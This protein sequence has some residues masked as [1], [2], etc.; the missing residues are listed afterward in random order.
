M[1]QIS[2]DTYAHPP[3]GT[4]IN[5]FNLR[6]D[7]IDRLLLID[8]SKDPDARYRGFEI[9][10]FDDALTGKGMLVIA[11][12]HDG[13]VDVY[14]QPGLRMDRKNYNVVGKGLHKMIERPF[15]RSR[16]E[17]T[18]TGVS[19]QVAFNDSKGRPIKLSILEEGGVPTRP[20][21]MLA[22][23]GAGTENPPS[24]PLVLL[25]DFYFV[26]KKGTDLAIEIDGKKHQPDSIPLR[27][28]GQSLHFIRYAAHPLPVF[29]NECVKGQTTLHTPEGPGTVTV[30]G[31]TCELVDNHG[32]LELAAMMAEGQGLTLPIRFDPPMPNLAAL[33][34][35][36]EIAGR[37]TIDCPRNAGRITGTYALARH[38][39][40]L[41]LR[42]HPSGGWQPDEKK[43]LLKMLYLVA[44][45]FRTWPKTYI[46]NATLD[47]EES[48]I[49]TAWQRTAS[50]T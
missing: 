2:P 21:D 25:F 42:V 35:G 27:L 22:P 3:S 31:M 7:P 28:D 18:E 36:A 24:L 5:P 37:I 9:Q 17:I 14:H 13:Q 10:A 6:V 47:L 32:H 26:R 50:G 15:E 46:W 44:P 30:D 41:H 8:F 19:L 40:T 16:F 39:Q 1:T 43:L 23:L 45:M 33:R 20:F 4:F 12:R 48:H 29:W 11:G 34:D 49:T 38:K